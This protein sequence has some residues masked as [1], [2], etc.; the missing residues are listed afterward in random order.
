M[1]FRMQ[2]SVYI[3]LVI[4]RTPLTVHLLV[5]KEKV[6]IHL[7][8]KPRFLCDCLL[9]SNEGGRGNPVDKSA[10]WPLVGER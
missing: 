9:E 3:V 2:H 8:D 4:I 6:R 10:G 5:V 7:T 1:I